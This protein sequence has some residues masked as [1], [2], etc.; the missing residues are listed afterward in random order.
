MKA[1]AHVGQ[2]YHENLGVTKGTDFDKIKPLFDMTRKLILHQA[3]EKHGMSTTD[4]DTIPCVRSTLLHDKAVKLSTAEVYVSDSVF[5]LTGRIA[6]Y[7]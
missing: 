1:A 6:E 5:C 2:D 3:H 4:W 7:P